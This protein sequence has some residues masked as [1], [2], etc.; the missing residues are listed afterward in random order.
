MLR[1]AHAPMVTSSI[2]RPSCFNAHWED[3]RPLS[4]AIRLAE[5]AA[6]A[7]LDLDP[8]SAIAHA[9]LAWVLDHNGEQ[10]AALGE[11]EA[12][13]ALDPKDPQG[14]LIRGHVLAMSGHPDEA[15]Q[16]LDMALQ[17]T[18]FPAIQVNL[19]PARGVN[20]PNSLVRHVRCPPFG[21]VQV[22]RKSAD[23]L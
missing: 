20:Q 23:T 1:S 21:C 5:G 22:D 13:L 12:A 17:D 10:E 19:A 8:Q 9:A 14:Y 15:T 16:A 11:A 18:E 7:A 4:E 2:C 3:C 6:R